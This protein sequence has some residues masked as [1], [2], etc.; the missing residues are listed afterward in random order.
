ML[1]VV[2]WVGEL[3]RGERRYAWSYRTV[4][5]NVLWLFLLAGSVY[6]FTLPTHKFL[7]TQISSKN[8]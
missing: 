4:F 8:M 1:I 5:D 3:A 7:I 2:S 6:A